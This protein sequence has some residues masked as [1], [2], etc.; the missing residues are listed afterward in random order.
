MAA[1][2]QPAKV[3]SPEARWTPQICTAL[4]CP[5][6]RILKATEALR[7]RSLT[8]SGSRPSTTWAWYHRNCYGVGGK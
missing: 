6:A 3:P 5:S 7:V 1:K 2:K 8:Y 4:S